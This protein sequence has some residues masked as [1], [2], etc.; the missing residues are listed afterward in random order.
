MLRIFTYSGIIYFI[1]IQSK[2]CDEWRYVIPADRFRSPNIIRI[3]ERGHQRITFFGGRPMVIGKHSLLDT[4]SQVASRGTLDS[5][6][7]NI[8]V[9]GSGLL[10]PTDDLIRYHRQIVAS[11]GHHVVGFTH[12]NCSFARMI[13]LPNDRKIALFAH[14]NA[15]ALSEQGIEII[16]IHLGHDGPY[17]PWLGRS[18]ISDPA[19]RHA[20]ALAREQYE[21]GIPAEVL[22][23]R[24]VVKGDWTSRVADDDLPLTAALINERV[25]QSLWKQMKGM[26]AS[27]RP[28]LI[29]SGEVAPEIQEMIE[30]FGKRQ[31]FFNHSEDLCVIQYNTAIAAG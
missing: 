25:L 14:S 6:I 5:G 11:P 29:F 13:G 8:Y 18:D 10:Q 26:P 22:P 23:S 21:L 15:E 9:P 7:V 19:I 2:T 28:E 16:H 17:H 4:C 1:Q 3:K 12:H 31:P 24:I 27:R 30:E 20:L